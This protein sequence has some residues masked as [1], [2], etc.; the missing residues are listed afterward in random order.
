MQIPGD[1]CS[2][3]PAHRQSEI[4][5]ISNMLIQHD[6]ELNA[7]IP[8]SIQ[9]EMGSKTNLGTVAW[10]TAES[11]HDDIQNRKPHSTD[12]LG[13]ETKNLYLL[14]KRPNKTKTH[15]KPPPAMNTSLSCGR[16]SVLT[17]LNLLPHKFNLC[18]VKQILI[19][20]K[21]TKWFC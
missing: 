10:V 5:K 11:P 21:Y 18:R 7:N 9:Q 12:C 3:L 16:H 20:E 17:T 2:N 6:A 8:K 14:L 15:R 1:E 19:I 4:S 13:S